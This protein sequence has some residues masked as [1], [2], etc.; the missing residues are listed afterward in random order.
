MIFTVPIFI[1]EWM[2][3]I[4]IALIAILGAEVICLVS[5]KKDGNLRQPFRAIFQPADNPAIGDAKWKESNPTY[6][7]FGLASSYIRRN[8]AYG[9][10][11]LVGMPVQNN[12]TIFGNPKTHD[13][14]NGVAGWYFAIDQ[15]GV[16][17]FVWVKSTGWRG[18]YGWSVINYSPIMKGSLNLV[19]FARKF[20]FQQ[21]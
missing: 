18:E 12:P 7:D 10:Q 21:G 19:F 6:S 15:Y 4:V 9:Y 17:Q 14:V 1:I 16:W 5:L 13:G 11:S 20:D 3:G 2:I 8:A